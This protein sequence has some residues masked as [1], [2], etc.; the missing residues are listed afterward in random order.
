MVDKIYYL[1]Y[2]I[3]LPPNLAPNL[4]NYNDYYSI[5]KQEIS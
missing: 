4:S 2:H 3:V 5:I 1:A